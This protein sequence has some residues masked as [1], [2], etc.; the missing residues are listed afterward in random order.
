MDSKNLTSPVIQNKT[1][2]Y[3]SVA[4]Y[5]NDFTDVI[6]GANLIISPANAADQQ[7]AA[8]AKAIKDKRNLNFFLAGCALVA[9]ALLSYIVLTPKIKI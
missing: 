2:V 9:L 6:T 4:D 3:K 8:D 7:A 5:F 1:A